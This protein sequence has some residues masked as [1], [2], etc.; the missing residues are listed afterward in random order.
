VKNSGGVVV[1]Q[2]QLTVNATPI[3]QFLKPST[4]SGTD[5]AAQAGNAWDFNDA[6]NVT[7]F[8]RTSVSVANGLMNVNTPS[9]PLPA[10]A[11]PVI[12]LNV[13][14]QITN[15]SAYR[16]LSYRIY[17]Q[18]PWQEIPNGMIVRWIW[19]IPVGC[20][21]VSNQIPFDV[22][23]QTYSVDLSDP[24]NGAVIQ[25]GGNCPA[26]TPSSW[27]TTSTIERIRFKPNENAL[28]QNM[29][30]QVDWVRLTQ[31]D[32]VSHGTVFPIQVSLNKSL[33]GVNFTFYYTDDLRN[34]SQ[35]RVV[36]YQNPAPNPTGPNRL[37]LPLVLRNVTAGT[38]SGPGYL[39]D[40]TAVAPGQY[41]VCVVADDGYNSATY[42]SD[43]PVNVS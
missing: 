33:S 12:Y 28:G 21:L 29:F 2:G 18:W 16:Y 42:C 30:Q 8:T 31:V 9:A 34:P 26:G 43:A 25:K 35:Q 32:Q 40:T 22:G 23:W 41:Y 11:D 36:L 37:Y 13:P 7:S 3:V 6:S 24:Y 10:G 4:T 17:T 20:D 5:Y 38:T 1:Q 27:S 14:Q 19:G 15:A 39:W